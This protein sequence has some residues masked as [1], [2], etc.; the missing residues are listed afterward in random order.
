VCGTRNGD[1]TQR[2]SCCAVACEPLSARPDFLPRYRALES[3]NLKYEGKDFVASCV[4]LMEEFSVPAG[5]LADRLES[6]MF[7]LSNGKV[8]PVSAVSGQ[9]IEAVRQQLEKKRKQ[10]EQPEFPTLQQRSESVKNMKPPT[11]TG[12][13]SRPNS[14]APPPLQPRR[15]SQTQSASFND[16]RSCA[17]ARGRGGA[18]ASG[19]SAVPPAPAAAAPAAA[20][21]HLGMNAVNAPDGWEGFA[22][23]SACGLDPH[24]FDFGNYATQ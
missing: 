9:H 10:E 13:R 16:V 22:K 17:P 11:I 8:N 3:N 21:L 1:S 5:D 7:Q 12:S 6:K 4:A 15:A 24:R 20:T 2:V 23:D 18:A 19:V 14:D